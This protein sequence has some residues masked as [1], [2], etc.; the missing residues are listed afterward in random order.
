MSKPTPKHF[1]QLGIAIFNGGTYTSKREAILDFKAHFGAHPKV[2]AKLWSILKRVPTFNCRVE[3]QHLLWTLF[4]IKTYDIERVC[5]KFLQCD[6]KTFRKYVW[7]TL[8]QIALLKE[9]V[10]SFICF[11]LFCFISLIIFL[12][13]MEQ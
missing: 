7:Y 1:F 2:C 3:P 9:V 13:C 12:D 4:F 10:V 11:V 6:R 8:K 5:S